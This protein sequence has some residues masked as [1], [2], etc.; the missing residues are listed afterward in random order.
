MEN[1]QAKDSG[2]NSQGNRGKRSGGAR[3]AAGRARAIDGKQILDRGRE[4][5]NEART[6]ASTVEEAFEEIEEYLR[7]QMEQRPY[8]ALAAASG[9]G[10]VLGGG[11]PSRLTGL[12]IGW[13][14]R[15]ALTMAVQQLAPALGA[16]TAQ[17]SPPSSTAAGKE[18]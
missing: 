8:V 1:T 2:Q 4:V 9:I 13:G 7:E 5:W 15:I 6:L 10:Y 17:H 14:S 11:L 18:R 12:L 3:S 16:G